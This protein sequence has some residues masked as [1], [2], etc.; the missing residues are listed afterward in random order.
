MKKKLCVLCLFAKLDIY[1]FL[2]DSKSLYT[3]DIKPL[4]HMLEIYFPFGNGRKCN[5]G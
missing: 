4:S 1:Q 5:I 2:T 3:K